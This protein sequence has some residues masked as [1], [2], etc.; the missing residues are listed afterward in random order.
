MKKIFLICLAI[1]VFINAKAI[2]T[3]TTIVQLN[4]VVVN[5]F[6]Q[7][8]NTIGG[9][10][11]RKELNQKNYGQEPSNLFSKMPSI[12]ALNDN[13]TEFG[14]G[15]FRIRGLDQ[16]RINVTL[17][18]CPW[19][20]AE[21]YGSYFANSPDLLS[22][23]ES[24]KVDRGSNSSYNGI[25]G[26][27]GGIMLESTNLYKDST[28]YAYIGYG[29]YNSLKGSVI[30]NMGNKNGFGLHIKATHQQSDGY[31][32][33]GFNKSESFTF[34]TGYKFNN[35]HSLDFLSMNGYHKNGQGWIGNSKHEL[36]INK[37]S[38][39]CSEH[40][41]DNWFMTMN[42]I[43]YKGWL[44]SNSILTSS[45][46]FQYQTGSYRFDLDNYMRRMVD[47]NW[48]STDAIYD[49]GLQH[50][51][52]G[53]NI[54]SKTYIDRMTLTAGVN[55][56]KYQR[57]HFLGDES[58]NVGN[59]EYY[60]NVGK[61]FD[62][63]V[64]LKADYNLSNFTFMG[65]IQYRYT[66][67]DYTDNVN[68]NLSFQHSKMGTNWHFVNFGLGINYK[69]NNKMLLYSHFSNVNR[70]P[71]RSDMFGGNENFI[72]ELSTIKHEVANDLELGIE[73]N[74]T[75]KLYVGANLFYMWFNNELVLNGEYG[76]NG[77]PCHENALKSY[78]MGAEIV[79]KYSLFKK[80]ELSA[81]LSLSKNKVK[82]KTFGFKNHILSP[83][84]TA[85]ADI[86]W[87][88][89]NWNIGINANYHSSMHV[90]ML[91]DYSVPYFF[92]INCYSTIN[93]FDNIELGLRLNN[94]TSRV[95][96]N[97]GMIGANN[98]MLY[99]QNAPINFNISLKY[100]F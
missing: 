41:D 26:V 73:G 10:L 39:G 50:S 56:Y 51:M 60:N 79:S 11:S 28:S 88:D 25:A 18:G 81:N 43:Q 98:E 69:I 3:D 61:K 47:K 67:F 23:M 12:I 30:Y 5:S 1:F 16:T 54:V 83:Q 33:Y 35:Y 62:T 87:N 29:S 32:D 55:G 4:D 96:Y 97:T 72:G 40:E 89:S 34:K 93:L 84:A 42:R 99:I 78:R 74:V 13:G 38:N 86:V 19:N 82:T 31:R 64:F 49:Y 57:K 71:T 14:Y 24:V 90:D 21:D 8:N 94:V 58:I 17:D 70:E 68:N 7:K 91:N 52:I 27:A 45:I 9:S 80:L 20:E 37:H 48:Q 65:N 22:S 100:M 59:D 53:A 63:N 46:Y 36:K 75:D 77:L 6:Y 66:F 44:S 2:E 95:N 15:Y 76:M 92:T 85:N